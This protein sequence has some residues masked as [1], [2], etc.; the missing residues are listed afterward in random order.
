M[1]RTCR[2]ATW[3][4]RWGKLSN[5]SLPLH[6]LVIGFDF[7]LYS[8]HHGRRG[9]AHQS[10]EVSCSQEKSKF[11]ASDRWRLLVLIANV[12]VVCRLPNSKRKRRPRRPQLPEQKHPKGQKN[13]PKM[14]RLQKLRRKMPP[15]RRNQM[16]RPRNM[17]PHPPNNHRN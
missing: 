15:R 17:K 3:P 6:H 4:V 13:P 2:S 8:I 12:A 16:S 5:L 10:R 1:R 14:P 9:G 7:S 11:P